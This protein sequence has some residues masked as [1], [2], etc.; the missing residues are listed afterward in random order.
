MECVP[1][2]FFV[3]LAA[4]DAAEF[5]VAAMDFSIRDYGHL[6]DHINPVQWRVLTHAP[7]DLV[8]DFYIEHVVNSENGVRANKCH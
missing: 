4:S 2:Q 6:E 8:S 3:D 1:T 7:V 5:P